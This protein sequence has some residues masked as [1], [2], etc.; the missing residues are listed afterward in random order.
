VRRHA[1]LASLAEFKQSAKRP[2]DRED[3]EQFEVIGADVFVVFA[4][5]NQSFQQIQRLTNVNAL[6]QLKR[7]RRRLLDNLSS[8][9][10]TTI[11]WPLEGHYAVPFPSLAAKNAWNL[12]ICAEFEAM[13]ASAPRHLFFGT[14]LSTAAPPLDPTAGLTFKSRNLRPWISHSPTD[15]NQ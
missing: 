14:L 7:N 15:T 12:T 9:T 11:L 8:H 10:H 13:L 6:Q 4:L 2:H 3:N 5:W 1:H